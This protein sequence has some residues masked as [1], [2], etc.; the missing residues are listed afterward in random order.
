MF[1]PRVQGVMLGQDFVMK[2]G[3]PVLLRPVAESVAYKNA[4][5]PGEEVVVRTKRIGTVGSDAV[6]LRHE[7]TTKRG[8]AAEAT[9]IRTL[10][11]GDGARWIHAWD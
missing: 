3:D 1:R 6:V 4:V 11:D 2:N 7:M 10:A 5:L 9:T 8:S